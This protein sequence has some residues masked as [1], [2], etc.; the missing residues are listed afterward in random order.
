M[1]IKW[2]SGDV[3]CATNGKSNFGCANDG[4][5]MMATKNYNNIMF[6]DLTKTGPHKA[7]GNK[8]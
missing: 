8:R 5:M 1:T 6:P 2:V 7:E 4:Y 3:R